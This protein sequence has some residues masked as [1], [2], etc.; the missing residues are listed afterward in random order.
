LNNKK[1]SDRE[2]SLAQG[3]CVA[4]IVETPGAILIAT[5]QRRTPNIDV[6]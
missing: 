3:R 4:D 1:A 6:E 2:L 5:I